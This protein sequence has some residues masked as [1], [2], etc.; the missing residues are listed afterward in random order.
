M[1]YVPGDNWAICDISGIKVLQSQTV[2]TWD[3]L[4]VHPRY[5]YPRHP[6]LEV[7]GVPDH[8]EVYDGRPEQPD[9][10][11][12]MAFGYGSFT[13]S[14]PDGTTWVIS[15]QDGGTIIVSRGLF[16]G[17]ADYFDLGSFRYV[18]TDAGVMV[19]VF[20]PSTYGSAVYGLSMYGGFPGGINGPATWTMMSPDGTT[21]SVSPATDGTW[22]AVPVPLQGTI[23]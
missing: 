2:K 22:V 1:P 11:I 10:F 6:Q 8:M 17:V 5:W 13:L 18:V 3:G 23:S 7:K 12:G 16:G 21:Y 4:R 20:A 15:I 14:S 19:I 9:Q